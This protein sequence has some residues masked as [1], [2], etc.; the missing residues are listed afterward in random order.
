MRTCFPSIESMQFGKFQRS[1]YLSAMHLNFY[2][3]GGGMSR[4][5]NVVHIADLV[6]A[7][8]S[9]IV[10]C[11]LINWKFNAAKLLPVA[12]YL[13]TNT[14]YQNHSCISETVDALFLL[15][16]KSSE[17]FHTGY[18]SDP[19]IFSVAACKERWKHIRTVFVH[20][21]HDK[22]PSG[23]S[24]TKK[25]PYYL[26]DAVQFM[27]PHITKNSHQESN[28]AAP[29]TEEDTAFSEKKKTKK[30]LRWTNRRMKTCRKLSQHRRI[31]PWY[32]LLVRQTKMTV[33]RRFLANDVS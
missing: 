25:R 28:L 24:A 15:C 26:H 32:K 19:F 8:M 3:F 6:S 29:H 14:I 23:S 2:L 31:L 21:L 33:G 18:L 30:T 27:I 13:K 10:L 5:C 22:I 4:G 9:E 11:P 12:K 1:K 17:F 20:R 16:F 7:I